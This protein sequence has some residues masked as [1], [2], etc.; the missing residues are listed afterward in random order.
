MGTVPC[1]KNKSIQRRTSDPTGK[2]SEGCR[3]STCPQDMINGSQKRLGGEQKTVNTDEKHYE[4]RMDNQT[5]AH[6]YWNCKGEE[7][8]TRLS[9]LIC[10]RM[11]SKDMT[12]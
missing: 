1:L 10:R 7:F 2:S 6:S 11:P 4:R 3:Y 9:S 8:N 5:S 12:F